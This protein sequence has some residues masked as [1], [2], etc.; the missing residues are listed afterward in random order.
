[1]IDLK[2][3]DMVFWFVGDNSRKENTFASSEQARAAY[4]LDAGGTLFVSGSEIGF[5][6]DYVGHGGSETSD[7][8]FYRHYLKSRLIHTGASVLTNSFGAEGTPFSE[9]TFDFGGIY[10]ESEPDDI[11]PVYGGEAMINYDF[12]R[13]DDTTQY[14]KCA[15]AFTGK[16]RESDKTGKMFYLSLGFENI[17]SDEN[18]DSL[19]GRVLKYFGTVTDVKE[20]EHQTVAPADYALSNNYPNPFNP[21]THF[22]VTLPQR[23]KLSVKVFDL[24]GRE[25]AEIF[26]GVKPSGRHEFSWNAIN[27]SSGVYFVKVNAGE[28]S[29]TISVMLVK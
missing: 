19:M 17:N 18:R 5:D 26:N 12:K 27:S 22:K 20:E 14:R 23:Q 4:Y 7:T 15:V 28:F 25:V 9:L 2:D 29:K 11:E 6:L 13:S 8:L 24:L 16:F 10:Q 3:Y 21:V 1:M